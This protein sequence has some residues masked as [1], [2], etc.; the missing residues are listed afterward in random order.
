MEWATKSKAAKA[1]MRLSIVVV[2]FSS[3][4]YTLLLLVIY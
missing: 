1:I 2:G 3:W 4:L